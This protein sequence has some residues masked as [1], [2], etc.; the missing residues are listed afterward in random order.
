[1]L[2][3]EA[4]SDAQAGYCKSTELIE[5]SIL[6]YLNK[7]LQDL[8]SVWLLLDILLLLKFSSVIISSQPSIKSLMRLLNTDTDQVD[9]SIVEN[10]LSDLLGVL[11]VM[12]LFITLNHLKP[13]SVTL[14]ALKLLFQEILFKQKVFFWLLSEIQIQSSFSNLKLFIE[15]LKPM[16]QLEISS[17]PFKK[18]KL[19]MKEKTLQLSDMEI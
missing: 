10:W 16:F 11:L 15:T 4:Y 18:L 3:L 5:F 7:V 8:P 17:L 12:V 6:H 13:I 2:S 19:L 9:N 1:M 14:Q